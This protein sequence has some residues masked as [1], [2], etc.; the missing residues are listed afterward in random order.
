MSRLRDGDYTIQSQDN[1]LFIT[2]PNDGGEP[3]YFDTDKSHHGFPSPSQKWTI[4]ASEARN[5]AL[6]ISG[7][8]AGQ[9]EADLP[10]V[11]SSTVTIRRN[12]AAPREAYWDIT[13]TDS[14]GTIRMKDGHRL[15]F[16]VGSEAPGDPTTSVVLGE[17]GAIFIFKAL[18]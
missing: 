15:Y 12:D 3:L 1:G 2:A 7:S 16:A 5:D 11:V 10:G 17:E 9:A 14:K 4:S 13:V 8:G 6:L 18:W